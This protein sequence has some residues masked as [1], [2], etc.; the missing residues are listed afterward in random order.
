MNRPAMIAIFSDFGAAGPYVGQMKA[1]IYRELPQA[2]VVDLMADAPTHNPRAAA[3]L[4]AALP[5]EFPVGTVFLC[6][7]DPGVG[8]PGRRPAAVA[9][10]GHWFVGPDNGLF[11]VAAM[12]GRNVQW[13][14]IIWQPPRLSASFHGRDLFA[15]VAARLARGE[16]PPGTAAA[17]QERL[18]PDWPQ[19]LAEIVYIDHFGNAVT[20][21]RA[22]D[23]SHERILRLNKHTLA[24]ARTFAAVS[25]GQAFWYENANGLVE[26]AVNRGRT[27]QV[28]GAA[29]G[30][31]VHIV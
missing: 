25:E 12:R 24:Y 28:L 3:Y 26:I 5:R 29:S 14:D 1:A 19:D 23:L 7:V 22:A 11:N 2:T 13:W 10:D 17:L 30:D 27:D 8:D 21:M 16:T 9:I 4:L 18:L 31:S 15:P 6:V 20:G